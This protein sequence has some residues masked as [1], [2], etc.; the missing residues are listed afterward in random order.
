MT[1]VANPLAI[2]AAELTDGFV[3]VPTALEM[4]AFAFGFRAAASCSETC[5]LGVY[6][7]ANTC[8]WDYCHARLY[9]VL[10][11][12]RRAFLRWRLPITPLR[13][14][15]SVGFGHRHLQIGTPDRDRTCRLAVLGTAALPLMLPAY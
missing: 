2:P 13:P 12:C 15:I 9:T 11:K 6:F 7:G 10:K 3:R 4:D 8:F 14:A 5:V 1:A